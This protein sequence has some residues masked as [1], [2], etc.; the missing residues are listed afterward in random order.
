MRN[1]NL[2]FVRAKAMLRRMRQHESDRKKRDDIDDI[3]DQIDRGIYTYEK[4]IDE[5]K[6]IGVRNPSFDGD[7]I[8]W[9][10]DDVEDDDDKPQK[11]KKQ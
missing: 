6:M 7:Y 2:F 9:L 10:D 8:G 1:N 11:P 5:A 4:W 3:L